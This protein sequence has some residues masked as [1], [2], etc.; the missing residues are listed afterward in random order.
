MTTDEYEITQTVNELQK[1]FFPLSEDVL[2]MGIY[3]YLAEQFSAQMINAN[4]QAIEEGNEAIPI[5][6]KYEK[7]ILTY[8]VQYNVKNINATPSHMDIMIGFIEDELIEQVDNA[9]NDILTIDKNCVITIGEFE[10]HFDYDILIK[11]QILPNGETTFTA[12]YNIDYINP[13]SDITNPYLAPPIKL[14]KDRNKMVFITCSIRQVA[15]STISKKIISNNILENKSFDFEFDDQLASFDVEVIED[16]DTTKL[17]PIFEGMPLNNTEKYCYYTYIDSNHIRVKFDRSVYEPRLN[18]NVNINLKT[19]K[20]ESGNFMYNTDFFVT[21]KSDSINYGNFQMWVTPLTDSVEGANRKSKD[22]IKEILPKQILARETIINTK[23]I[24]NFFNS[25]SVFDDKLYFYKRRDN[26]IQRLYYAYILLKD[27]NNNIIPTNTVSLTIPESEFQHIEDDRCSIYMDKR[28]IYDKENK[29]AIPDDEELTE[30]EILEKEKSDFL[31]SVPFTCVLNKTPLS[32]SY[33]LNDM[34]TDYNVKFSYINQLSDVQFITTGINLRRISLEDDDY[35]FTIKLQQNINIDKGLIVYDEE[36]K[37]IIDYLI[38]PYLYINNV[39]ESYYVRGTITNVETN[40]YFYTVEFRLKTD[41]IINQMN[42]IKITNLQH[43]GEE[44]NE[45]D[46]YAYLLQ[47][48]MMSIFVFVKLDKE[49][50][51]N[52]SDLLFGVEQ[53]K[54]YTLCNRYDIVDDV[55]LFY[56]FSNIIQ[57]TAIVENPDKEDDEEYVYTFKH[58]PV[59][60]YSYLQDVDRF[61]YFLRYLQFRQVFINEAL[62][63]L[64]NSFGVDLK[65]FNTYGVS[66]MFTIGRSAQEPLDKP[67]LSLIFDVKLKPGADT[68]AEDYIINEIKEYIENI[69]NNITSIHITNLTTDITNKFI[70]D[71]EYIEFIGINNYNALYQYIEKQDMEIQEI[72]AVPEFLNINLINNTD[73]DIKINLV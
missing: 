13:L 52:D 26:Q 41:S 62:E 67:N 17:T 44:P 1:K 43:A 65:F 11:R 48:L 36:G 15:Q 58:I 71:I 23:D 47:S 19:T 64:E 21:L 72:G 16:E 57:S 7:N 12:T 3:G 20:G 51:R 55:N 60:R 30:D 68:Y 8:A 46:T 32:I 73:P 69:N 45:H 70:N 42:R 38:K 40:S 33:Y 50:G 5:N 18:Y 54:D 56:N 53:N 29:I 25:L 22:E 59:V 10:Y 35:I 31:Y 61:V 14:N 9:P 49:Y 2:Y 39:K 34:D 66:E 27:T 63:I 4:I 28:F 37:N 24:E 6:S